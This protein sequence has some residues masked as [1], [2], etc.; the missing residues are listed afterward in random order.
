M[1]DS[2]CPQFLPSPPE[3]APES[4]CNH[5]A[6]LSSPPPTVVDR[7]DRFVDRD[8]KQNRHYNNVENTPGGDQT[9]KTKKVQFFFVNGRANEFIRS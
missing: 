1:T 4:A 2:A 6:H 3:D 5:P 7:V 9:G 8:V